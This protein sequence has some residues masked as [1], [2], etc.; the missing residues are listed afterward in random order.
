MSGYTK[1]FSDILTSSI[2][3]TDTS[4][5]IV[6]I[7]MLA[8]KDKDGFVKGSIGNLAHMARVTMDEAEK[9]VAVLESPDSDTTTPDHEGR[10]IE[11]VQGGWIVLNHEIYKAKL[12]TDPDVE[13]ARERMRRYRERKRNERNVT[14]ESVTKRNSVSVSD[15]ASDEK[16]IKGEEKKAYGEFEGVKLTDTEHAK[17][18]KKHGAVRLEQGIEILDDY[19]RSKGKRYKDHYAALKATSWVWE[20]VD[21]DA[22]GGHVGAVARRAEKRIATASADKQRAELIESLADLLKN[23]EGTPGALKRCTREVRATYGQDAVAEAEG[24]AGV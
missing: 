10:R 21:K 1:L 8:M 11:R 16:G 20:R 22:G 2:W 24:M 12:S 15:Y 18:T 23:G 6:W 4:T 14:E 7:A 13:K 19:M 9:A 3:L 5:R 17:L